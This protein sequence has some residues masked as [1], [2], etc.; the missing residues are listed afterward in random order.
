MDAKELK[1]LGRKELLELLLEQTRR[2]DGLEAELK[3]AEAKL[4][5]RSL[6]LKNAGSIAQ[7]ALAINDVFETCQKAANEY[8]MNIKDRTGA[9]DLRIATDEQALDEKLNAKEEQTEVLCQ[10]KIKDAE[11]EAK[12]ILKDAE[13]KADQ[14][15]EDAQEKCDTMTAATAERIDAMVSA[16]KKDSEE[17][18]NSVREKLDNYYDSH[19]GLE[20]MLSMLK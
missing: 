5:D 17:Y 4:A 7:A 15:I 10:K 16:A 3:E 2:A 6:K 1:K 20:E 18:W 14:M 11:E 13:K 12:K 8:L 9:M 19:K